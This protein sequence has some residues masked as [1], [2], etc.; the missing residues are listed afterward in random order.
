MPLGAR[1]ISDLSEGGI[2]RPC[3]PSEMA[4]TKWCGTIPPVAHYVKDSE[5][6]DPM[7]TATLII[8]ASFALGLVLASSVLLIL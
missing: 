5:R 7:R 2:A 4:A 1:Q 3:F 6:N 8:N